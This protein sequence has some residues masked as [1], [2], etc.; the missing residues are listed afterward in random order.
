VH[1]LLGF[2][3]NKHRVRR[4]IDVSLD[5]VAE[6]VIGA[7]GIGELVQLFLGMADYAARLVR[8]STF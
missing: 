4:L 6:R 8:S 5:S 3:P 1:L 2:S 7:G